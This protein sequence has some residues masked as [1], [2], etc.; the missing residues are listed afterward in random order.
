VRL[1][2]GLRWGMARRPRVYAPGGAYHLTSRGVADEAIFY[3]AFDCFQ[4]LALLRDVT[5]RIG[6]T[7]AAWCFMH[8]HYHLVVVA[9]RD[10]RLSEAMQRLNGIYARE[11]NQ[12]HHRRGHLFGKRYAPTPIEDERHLVAACD[13]VLLNPVTAGLTRSAEQWT[14]SG[15]ERLEPRPDVLNRYELVAQL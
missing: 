14:W 9:D 12:R 10:A 2:Y 7:V 1:D 3:S 11:F 4:L 6:W 5:R 15:D 13:Y 8:T